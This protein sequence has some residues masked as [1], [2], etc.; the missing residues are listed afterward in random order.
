MEQY[1]ASVV[2][3]VCAPLQKGAHIYTISVGC[4]FSSFISLVFGDTTYSMFLSKSFYEFNI[5]LT[6][7]NLAL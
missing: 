5:C 1:D 2:V 7:V 3:C 6:S 4:L